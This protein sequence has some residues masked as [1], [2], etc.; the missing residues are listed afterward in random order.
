MLESVKLMQVMLARKQPKL[1]MRKK[2]KK[3]ELMLVPE[4]VL[5]IQWSPLQRQPVMLKMLMN[6]QWMNGVLEMTK[7]V[8]VVVMPGD[9]QHELAGSEWAFAGKKREWPGAR[10]TRGSGTR[11]RG[12]L[13]ITEWHS[14]RKRRWRRDWPIDWSDWLKQLIAG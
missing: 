7:M 11:R 6:V 5:L 2:R 10:W 13:K 4:T 1:K 3:T 8:V 14:F 12:P 9:G